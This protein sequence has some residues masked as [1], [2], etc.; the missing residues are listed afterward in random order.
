M[1][2]GKDPGGAAGPS[3]R[4]NGRGGAAS[5]RV[6]VPGYVFDMLR[7]VK[8]GEDA[9]RWRPAA[10]TYPGWPTEAAKLRKSSTPA[11]GRATS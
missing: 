5:R 3:S 8:E 4:R 1:V 11:A 6:A 2:G 7:F 9:P 10:G